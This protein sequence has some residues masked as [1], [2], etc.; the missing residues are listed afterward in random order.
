MLHNH[1]L[2]VLTLN[3]YYHADIYWLNILLLFHPDPA[4]QQLIT[5]SAVE[6]D[7][8]ISADRQ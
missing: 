4:H 8:L 6:S 2:L 3:G 5:I 1:D 7:L